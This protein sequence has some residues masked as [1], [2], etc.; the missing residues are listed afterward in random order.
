[1][2]QYGII[3]YRVEDKYEVL[4]GID[5]P[6]KK[7]R[8]PHVFTLEDAI[9]YLKGRRSDA[10]SRGYDGARI[11]V[12]K[13]EKLGRVYKTFRMDLVEIPNDTLLQR[14]L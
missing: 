9:D 4:V 8:I 1:M 6:E 13:G 12:L 2:R 10:L 11:H 5:D 7:K 14:K 3:F